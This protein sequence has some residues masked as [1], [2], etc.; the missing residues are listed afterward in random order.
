[1]DVEPPRLNDWLYIYMLSLD[2][3]CV[4]YERSMPRNC[5][6]QADDRVKELRD[7]GREAFYTIGATFKGAFY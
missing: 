1:M 3:E 6:R 5:T 2:G 4:L 7:Y